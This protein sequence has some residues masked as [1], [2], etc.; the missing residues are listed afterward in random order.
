MGK[1]MIMVLLGTVGCVSTS[2]DMPQAK[3]I[4]VADDASQQ[5]AWDQAVIEAVSAWDTALDARG[6]QDPFIMATD[7]HE[8]RLVLRSKW[9]DA[10]HVGFEGADGIEVRSNPDNGPPLGG[11]LLH[12]LGHAMGLQHSDPADGPSIMTPIPGT[13]LEARDIDAAAALLGC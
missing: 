9:S 11:S 5:A 4:A 3:V 13:G 6:C 1:L 12:E 10:D 2:W 8:V 7:G